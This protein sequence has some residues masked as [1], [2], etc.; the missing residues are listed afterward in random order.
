MSERILC[1][2]IWYREVPLK[3]EITGVLPKNVD[4]GIVITGHRHG[5]CIWTMCCLT[6]L[7]TGAKADDATGDHEQGFLTSTNRFV[8]REEAAI[9]HMNNGGHLSYSTKELFSE[10]LY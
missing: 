8:N 9:I 10:D 5:Q 7:R 1:A 3:M 6:G 2:A 4:R